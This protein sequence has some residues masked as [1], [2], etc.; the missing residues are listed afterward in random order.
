[1][2]NIKPP[3]MNSTLSKLTALKNRVLQ[4]QQIYSN[5]AADIFTQLRDQFLSIAQKSKVEF[6]DLNDF[7]PQNYEM[8]NSGEDSYYKWATRALISDIEYFIDYLTNISS[9]QL[10]NAVVSEEGVY[11]AGQHFDALLKFSDIIS[12]SSSEIILI[13]NY[14]NE[15]ILD[16]IASKN[17]SVS[18]RILTH[19]RSLSNSLKTFIEAF[20]EQHGNLEV[21]TSSAFHDRF[22]VIDKTTFYHFGASIKDAGKKGFMF[23]KIEQDFI[24]ESLLEKVEAEWNK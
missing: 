13:D 8:F 17:K 2:C 23:S 7:Q 12:K 16:L 1:V 19:E 3:E 10:P 21:R 9:V 11:F 22:V 24:K 5:P 20:N 6:E 4:V 18:C 15:K 14:L